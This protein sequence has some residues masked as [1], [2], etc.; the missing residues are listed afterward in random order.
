[1]KPTTTTTTQLSITTLAQIVMAHQGLDWT[2]AE[3]MLADSE[4]AALITLLCN[5]S[6]KQESEFYQ[7]KGRLLRW[8]LTIA[9]DWW[10]TPHA[11]G[12]AYEA[13]T[14]IYIQT[15]SHRFA[16]HVRSDD[17]A[18]AD[19]LLAPPRSDRGWG[20]VSLQ[21]IAKQLVVEWLDARSEAVGDDGDR[22]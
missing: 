1:M 10:A 4:G 13:D 19:L 14:V 7:F 11:Y 18:L 17:P 21:P 2:Q 3:T 22:S 20:G 5:A 15:P 6:A 8:A 12:D 9:A 16:F